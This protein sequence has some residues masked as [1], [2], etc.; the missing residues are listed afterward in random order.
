MTIKPPP[1][2][3]TELI[4][5]K[6]S[7]TKMTSLIAIVILA[8]LITVSLTWNL[9]LVSD[10][11]YSQV[12]S[13]ADAALQKDMSYRKFV[14]S[15][16]GVYINKERGIPP[17]MHLSH[18]KNK[19]ITTPNGEHLSLVNST[20]FMR[21]VYNNDEENQHSIQSH[22]SGKYPLNKKNTAN[23]WEKKAFQQFQAGKKEYSVIQTS[24]G[25]SHFQL[26]RPRFAES[27]CLGCHNNHD[28]KIG[29]VMGGVS[30]SIDY[31]RFQQ[32]A[33]IHSTVLIFGHI[34]FAVLGLLAIR[35]YFN[36][37]S[38]KEISLKLS[39]NYDSLTKL[40]NREQFTSL[41][42]KSIAESKQSGKHGA[43]ILIDLD[44]FK[45][46]NDS[47]GH[48][49]GDELIKQLAARMYKTI[50]R[51]GIIARLGG[52]E[53]V[54]LL[55]ELN[56][57]FDIATTTA[58]SYSRRL[59]T[60][61]MEAFTVENNQLF[62]TLSMGIVLFPEQGESKSDILKY[63]DSAMY[64]A[65]NKGRNTY[66]LFLP[67]LKTQANKRHDIEVDLHRA[68][69]NQEFEL[70]Y[71]PQ[72]DLNG[73]IVGA[74]ALIRWFHPNQGLI[75]PADFIPIA[76]ETGQIVKIGHWV[77]ETAIK[78][79]KIWQ[80]SKACA[81]NFTLSVNVSSQQFYRSN[82]IKTI[83]ELIEKEQI[84]AHQLKLEITE[85]TVVEDFQATVKIMNVLKNY[86]IHFSLDDFGTGY[87]SLTYLQKLPLDQLK[88]DQSFV[89][90]INKNKSNAAIV[91][92]IVSMS[93]ALDLEVIVEGVEEFAQ[94]CELR[95]MGCQLIQGY[96]FY[97]P[98]T[99]EQFCDELKYNQ[100]K[101]NITKTY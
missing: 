44:R 43:V 67:E 82:F 12:Y 22:V 10:K 31:D 4:D 18:L 3:Y 85:G 74:E 37:L 87:S 53:F 17:N 89:K 45:N 8:L 16:G 42:D 13:L 11:T 97:H 24:N 14:S 83:I 59:K 100:F 50:G 6:A 55:P 5:N 72:V 20:Y 23:E 32:Q 38:Q 96:M 92:T 88:I 79:L 75:S 27:K 25:K 52:D 63:A 98:L 62:V 40:P 56:K 93:K 26:I 21:L 33:T 78:Q 48:L 99:L 76:E 94:L 39:S 81:K 73:Q 57:D 9:F 29:D 65:K 28:Y 47:L 1:F 84:D 90:H 41:L 68:I 77:L 71:Q 95:A 91:Q 36:N 69:T 46:I 15:V 51:D 60:N 66:Q 30:V 86:G 64:L 19:E 35:I 34:L 58:E 80:S 7:M 2:Y 70:Y 101:A 54:I 49:V 61:M